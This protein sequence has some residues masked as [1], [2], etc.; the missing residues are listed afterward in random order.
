MIDLFVISSPNRDIEDLC[1]KLQKIDI[2]N[3]HVVPGVFLDSESRLKE[4]VY[5][6]ERTKLLNGRELTLGEIGCALA[7][8][9]CRRRA[10]FSKNLSI[11][12]EDDVGISNLLI[13][14]QFLQIANKTIK[15]DDEVVI[16][17]AGNL[18]R[19]KFSLYPKAKQFKWRRTIGA[20]PLA[21]A[22]LV[23][24]KSAEILL[25]KNTPITTVADWP[26]T[27]IKF[28]KS[29]HALFIHQ[30]KQTNSL[31]SEK[32]GNERRGFSQVDVINIYL[33]IYYL[34]NK[35]F[36][37]GL[38]DFY[39]NLWLPRVKSLITHRLKI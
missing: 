17:L 12:L 27:K 30:E 2:L 19:K 10:L 3:V 18:K 25:A 5:D 13:L 34:R 23:T 9:E 1:N 6:A 38:E 14:Q 21:A 35:N 8:N 28:K 11:V 31:I 16:N 20:T 24:P 36:F 37:S 26:P 15:K 39:A 32:K 7:H 4:D 22:Y 33:G 29:I